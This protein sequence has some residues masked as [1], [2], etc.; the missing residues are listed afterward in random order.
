MNEDVKNVP[1]K[2]HIANKHLVGW[3][4]FDFANSIAAIIGGIYFA[5]WFIE[6]VQASPVTLNILFFVSAGLILVTGKLI[7]NSIDSIGYKF[8]IVASTILG[9]FSILLLFL[10]SQVVGSK[11]IIPIS[12]VINLFFLFSY[13]IGRI[14]HNVYLR[15]TIP[16]ELQSRMSGFGAAANWAGSI[17]GVLISI[18][19]VI[20][21]PTQF[22][23]ELTFLAAALF[24]GCLTSIAL[25]YMLQIKESVSSKRSLNNEITPTI[26]ILRT[27]LKPIIIYFILFDVMITVQKNLP[28]FLTEVHQMQD[29]SQAIRFLVILISA[30]IG[31]LIAARLV[32]RKNSKRWLILSSFTLTMA[33]C[34]IT[35][36]NPTLLWLSFILAG[37]SYG[38]LESAIRVDFMQKF[39][40]NV[41]GQNFGLLA[42][43]E[44][45]SGVVGPVLWILPFVLSN[46]QQSKQYVM[47]MWLMGLLCMIAFLLIIRYDREKAK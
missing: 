41:A 17:T 35:V 23:R 31:G 46:Q 9:F 27:S 37:I 30:M 26:K 24:Y 11:F 40:S 5:K 45:T 12:F 43:I 18:P 8:W 15:K 10:S 42:I 16:E 1:I 20:I 3:C 25:F 14:C 39:T 29:E 33:I 7:G 6:D 19:I 38:I 32:Y 36:S 4:L 22:G 13:Q 21:Y 44:R 28:N 47:S 2:K 34:I